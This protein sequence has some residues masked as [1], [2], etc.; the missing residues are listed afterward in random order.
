MSALFFSPHTFKYFFDGVWFVIPEQDGSGY[1]RLGKNRD[2]DIKVFEG[3]IERE[4]LLKFKPIYEAMFLFLTENGFEH[5][6][7]RN[8]QIEDFY[9]ERWT[10]SGAKEQHIWWR[11]KKDVQPYI[12]YFYQIDWQTLNVTKSEGAYKGKKISGEKIDLIIRI[13]AWVQFDYEG[14]FDNSIIWQFKK[15]FFGKM[16]KKELDH[17]KLALYD[18]TQDMIRMLKSIMEMTHDEGYRAQFEPKMGYKEW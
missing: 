15:A 9:W 8:D 10:Q 11:V 6:L 16:Y 17:H 4:S 2:L 14:K 5:P 13:K 1:L 7:A 12:R 18:F 3:E